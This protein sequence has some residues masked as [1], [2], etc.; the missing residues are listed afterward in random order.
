MKIKM[1]EKKLL[2]TPTLGNMTTQTKSLEINLG[3]RHKI[4]PTDIL[5][6]L[7]SDPKIEGNDV[8]KIHIF[9]FH[10]LIAIRREKLDLAFQILRK[11]SIKRKS[12]KVRKV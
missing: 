10:S 3:K 2:S 8:G 9:D 5:G 12:V 7:T 1:G 11:R 6:T 4:R